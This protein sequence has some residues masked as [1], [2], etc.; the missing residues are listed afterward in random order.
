[1]KKAGASH[2][3]IFG[4]VVRSEDTKS[5]DIDFLVD[6]DTSNGIVPLM[7]LKAA[8]SSLL[9]ERVDVASIDQPLEDTCLACVAE[10]LR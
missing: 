8:L 4:S 10:Q 3:R 6:F 7:K 9:H 5:S 1:M 2:V